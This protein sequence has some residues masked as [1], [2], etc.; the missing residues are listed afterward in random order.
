MPRS[1]LGTTIGGFLVQTG[2]APSVGSDLAFWIAASQLS[3]ITSQKTS[4]KQEITRLGD[5]SIKPKNLFRLQCLFNRI[6]CT[7]HATCDAQF[8]EGR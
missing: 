5:G 1:G 3:V 7:H 8:V 6:L 2:Y 4:P